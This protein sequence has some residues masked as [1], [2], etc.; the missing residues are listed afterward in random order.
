M[1]SCNATYKDFMTDGNLETTRC[2]SFVEDLLNPIDGI[3]ACKVIRQ[4]KDYYNQTYDPAPVFDELKKLPLHAQEWAEKEMSYVFDTKKRENCC[5]CIAIT[6]YTKPKNIPSEG[7]RFP[8]QGYLV[9]IKRTVKNV[10]VLLPHWLVRLYID[11]SVFNYIYHENQEDVQHE[12]EILEYLLECNNVEIHTVLCPGMEGENIDK[13]RTYRFLPLFDPT[14]NIAVVREADGIVTNVD[15]HNIKVFENSNKLFYL[16]PTSGMADFDEESELWYAYSSWLTY[17]KFM[18]N[19]DYFLRN[20]NLTTFLAGTIA[21]KLRV[22]EGF[23]RYNLREISQAI[24]KQKFV[25][26]EEIKREFYQDDR[27]ASIYNLYSGTFESTK[28]LL[29]ILRIGFDEIFLLHLFRSLVSMDITGW[30]DFT[31]KGNVH[32]LRGIVVASED[33]KHFLF[34]KLMLYS[35]TNNRIPVARERSSTAKDLFDIGVVADT[36]RK[37]L[38]VFL[39]RQD[40]FSAK[41]FILDAYCTNLHTGDKILPLNV[42]LI[43]EPYYIYARAVDHIYDYFLQKL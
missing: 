34:L 4:R 5:N 12:R 33:D 22:K 17:Y 19:R 40:S 9:A 3:G 11:I 35:P 14:V 28:T 37:I 29:S 39:D 36:D 26:P 6:V 7:K 15:C 32:P 13:T 2:G 23:F 1:S 24:E 41:A 42:A 8:L 20:N 43:N 10:A 21:V 38:E 30:N 18:I 27:T 31:D 16:F 25:S